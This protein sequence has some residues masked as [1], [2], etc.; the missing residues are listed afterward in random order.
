MSLFARIGSARHLL[1]SMQ[2]SIATD[3][4]AGVIHLKVTEICT[5]ML[6]ET[7]AIGE[8]FVSQNG[9]SARRLTFA[10]FNR[11]DIW[12][13]PDVQGYE[14]YISWPMPRIRRNVK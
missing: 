2:Y 3:E 8:V 7:M 13:A 6:P 1:L 11:S 9:K 12:L 4:W 5:N 14:K 10:E